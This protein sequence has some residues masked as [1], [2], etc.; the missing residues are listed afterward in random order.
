MTQIT[1]RRMFESGVHFGHQTRYWNPQ[2]RPY[3]YG[4]RNK[5]HIINLDK[6][7]EKFREATEFVRRLSAR[8]KTVL[9]VGTKRAAAAAIREEA[10]RCGSPY[11]DHR[12]FGGTLTNFQT[13]RMSV[14]RLSDLEVKVDNAAGISKKRLL[15][16]TRES[17]KLRRN[18][19]GIRDMK[20]TPDALFVVDVGYER[21]A[22]KEAA[23]LD[24]PVIAVVDTNNS[25]DGV[26][27]MIPGN[28]DAINAIKL[29]ASAIADAIL[30]GRTE[31]EADE[32]PAAPAA[33]N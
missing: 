15:E 10:E 6:T 26:K 23:R 12:W 13:L 27:C 20:R 28:D 32:P 16:L 9:F 8:G 5:I 17:A 21:I 24:I 2:M 3:I 11:V 25:F 30:A 22:V 33:E 29:Y 7:I 19:G 14:Q 4:A 18:L 31:A 1:V